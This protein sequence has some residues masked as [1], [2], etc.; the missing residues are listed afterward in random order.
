MEMEAGGVVGAIGKMVRG[1]REKGV[2]VGGA[3][4]AGRWD[5]CQFGSLEVVVAVK[6]L[7]EGAVLVGVGVLGRGSGVL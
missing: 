1:L 2:G 7:G 6:A 5:V 4:E 3:A